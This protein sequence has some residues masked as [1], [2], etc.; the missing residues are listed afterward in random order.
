MHK[1]R[2]VQFIPLAGFL[3]LRS[4]SLG[5]QDDEARAEQRRAAENRQIL[6][7][8]A[9]G[10]GKRLLELRCTDCHGLVRVSAG[11]KSQISWSNTLQVMIANGAKLEPKEVAPLAQFLAANFGPAVNVNSATAGDLAKI[12]LLDDHLAAAIVAYREKN[13]PFTTVDELT[14]VESVSPELL[15]KI[16]GRITVGILPKKP[17]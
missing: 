14:N 8:L 6:S 9:D 16:R 15:R 10:E 7:E 12:P 11:H 2:A 5:Q 1:L 13:G 17:Q 3:I 4:S